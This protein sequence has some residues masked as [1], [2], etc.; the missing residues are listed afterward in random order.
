MKEAPDGRERVITLL[1]VMALS[2]LLVILGLATG[3]RQLSYPGLALWFIAL[4]ATAVWL[5]R[6]GQD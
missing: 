3:S 4:S 1:V 5:V 6:K 2:T